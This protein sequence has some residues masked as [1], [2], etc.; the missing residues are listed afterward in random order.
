MI[1]IT[2]VKE[3][4]QTFRDAPTDAAIPKKMSEIYPPWWNDV[5]LRRDICSRDLL[6]LWLPFASLEVNMF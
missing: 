6:D 3:N 5:F 4:R 2:A 1:E